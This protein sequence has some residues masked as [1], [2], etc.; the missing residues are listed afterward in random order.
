[1]KIAYNGRSGVSAKRHPY[2][3]P[4]GPLT[5]AVAAGISGAPGIVGDRTARDDHSRASPVRAQRYVQ[6]W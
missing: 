2:P 6:E 1:V 4:A 5:E 3:F